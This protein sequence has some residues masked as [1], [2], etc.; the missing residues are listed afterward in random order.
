MPSESSF[1]ECVELRFYGCH[2]YG[3]CQLGLFQLV[4]DV[5]IAHACDYTFVCHFVAKCYV[6]VF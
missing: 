4:V 6:R 1:V 2:S 5:D 3:G